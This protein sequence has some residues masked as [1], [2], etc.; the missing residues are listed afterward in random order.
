VFYA[1]CFPVLRFVFEESEVVAINCVPIH[2]VAIHGFRILLLHHIRNTFPSKMS[3]SESIF[4]GD[5]VLPRVTPATFRATQVDLLISL[6][7]REFKIPLQ[8]H[9]RWTIWCGPTTFHKRKGN[10]KPL[11]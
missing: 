2:G 4:E 6:R 11:C 9:L 1:L 5:D 8:V 10:R 7:E 3:Q